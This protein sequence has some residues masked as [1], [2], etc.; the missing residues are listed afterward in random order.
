MKG[1]HTDSS[2]ATLRQALLN[3]LR[4]PGTGLQLTAR[5]D[6]GYKSVSSELRKMVREGLI[7]REIVSG[8]AYRYEKV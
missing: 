3:A 5:T 6:W 8:E 4:I 2:G 7:T 1:R